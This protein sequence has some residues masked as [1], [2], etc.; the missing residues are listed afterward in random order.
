MLFFDIC[1]SLIRKFSD[2]PSRGYSFVNNI[3]CCK[4]AH[5]K[6]FYQKSWRLR[7]ELLLFNMQC[8]LHTKFFYFMSKVLKIT[9]GVIIVQHAMYLT[10]KII[11]F[12]VKRVE[13]YEGSY[14]CSTCNLIYTQNYFISFQKS[15]RL[16]RELLLF[17]MQF[18]LHTKLFY[19]IS[20]VLKITKGVIIVQHAI[21]L[22]NFYIQSIK[23]IYFTTCKV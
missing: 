19:F 1:I 6:L 4:I 13:D 11:L 20:K 10:H 9:K 14:Y 16:R 22:N 8:T 7:R 21:F 2:T 23:P 17:N 18:N 12:H 3:Q 15:W 5:T